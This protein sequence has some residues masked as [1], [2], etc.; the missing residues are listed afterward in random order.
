MGTFWG[1]TYDST[2]AQ[3]TRRGIDREDGCE[4]VTVMSYGCAAWSLNA[5]VLFA[6]LAACGAA[7][8]PSAAPEGSHPGSEVRGSGAESNAVAVH[9]NSTPIDDHALPSA[10]ADATAPVCTPP[11]DFVERLCD[12]PYQDV[13][14]SLFAG[15]TPFT[16]GYLRG[17]LDELTWGEEVLIV[18]F[19]GPQKGGIIV[20]SNL[21]TY[22]VLRWDGSCSI[23]VDADMITRAKPA[24]PKAARI[25]WH[26]MGAR[27]QDAL[28]AASEPVKRARAKRGKECQGAMTGDVSAACD[29]A[30]DT[31]TNAVVE[32]VRAGGALPPPDDVP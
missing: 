28:V 22:D 2:M 6:S 30:D 13:A 10:C 21:G 25:R 1:S 19:R 16:R 3:P 18:R 26:R 12:R 15:G 14:L 5:M 27:T 7:S 31:L 23:A 11:G 8:P 24:S 29:K 17:K 20:G 4:Q 32:Y 9:G